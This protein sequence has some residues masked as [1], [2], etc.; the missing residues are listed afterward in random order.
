M[1]LS[2]RW[3]SGLLQRIDR[4]DPGCAGA[5][6]VPVSGSPVLVGSAPRTRREFVERDREPGDWR[7]WG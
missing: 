2:A 7:F 6:R 1:P 5:R 4:V 3:V